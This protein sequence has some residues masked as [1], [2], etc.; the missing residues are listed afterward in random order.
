MPEE[1]KQFSWKDKFAANRMAFESILFEK[2]LIIPKREKLS[3]GLLGAAGIW[4][5][6]VILLWQWVLRR[7]SFFSAADAIGFERI[8][9]YAAHL[10]AGGF[11]SLFKPI[12]SGL[13]PDSHPPLYYISYFP[14]LKFLTSDPLSA[15]LMVNSAYLL[16]IALA[17]FLAVKRS[18]NNM[19]GWLGTA[20]AFGMPFV[21]ETARHPE[22]VLGAMAMAAAAY[23]CYI[24]SDDFERPN[25]GLWCAVFFSL[26]FFAH[27]HFWVFALPLIPYFMAALAGHAVR[28]ELLKGLLPGLALSFPWYVLFLAY[29]F[30]G[31]FRPES[32]SVS[33]WTYFG[34]SV[35]AAS[36]PFFVLYILWIF[37]S[38]NSYKNRV[39]IE[40]VLLWILSQK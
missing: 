37:G 13:G 31:L 36:L 34:L 25:W 5:I 24:N 15:M 10:S 38:F 1:K 28:S 2:E 12:L 6:G 32:Q 7:G 40:N 29:R 4:L 35:Q 30:S 19:S 3:T 27:R 17:V 16:I 33:F 23:C 26:G 22:P 14:V 21:L 9:A 20:F 18:R 39:N 11:W 8:N